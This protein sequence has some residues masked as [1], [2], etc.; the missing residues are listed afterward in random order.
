[1]NF[2]DLH[3]KL[4]ELQDSQ[5][6]NFAIKLLPTVDKDTIIGIRTP[7]LG[8]F[9][10]K[11]F[12]A[13]NAKEF[14]NNLPHRYFEENSIHTLIV[15]DIKNYDDC[16][17]AADKFLPYVDNWAT[18]DSLVPKIFAKH[19]ERLIVDI[20]RWID[21]N[22]TYTIR[23]GISMLMKFYLDQHFDKQ[24]LNWVAAIKFND[25]YVEMMA[26]WYFAEALVKQYDSAVVFLEQNLLP[27]S[28]HVKTIR[29]A[30]DSRRIPDKRKEYLKS[31]RVKK[32]NFEK[33]IL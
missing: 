13:D 27:R 23:F 2:D 8:R 15:S 20:K 19:T 1:M 4:F 21:S 5:Y 26:A 18:C 9:A 3:N 7:V 30:V 24:Y 33:A 22:S 12:H 11:Y 16:I 6:R 14:L 25:Y 17:Q 28:V 31:L 32:N 29:K 10:K